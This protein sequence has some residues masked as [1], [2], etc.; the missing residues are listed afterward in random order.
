MMNPTRNLARLAG[1]LALAVLLAACGGG[2][3]HQSEGPRM[4]V[5]GV[6][7][8]DPGL[9]QKFMDEGKMPNFK[10]L[11]EMGSFQPLGTSIPPLSP[12]A[13]SNFMTGLDSGG[14]GIFDFVHRDPGTMIPFLATSKTTPPEYLFKVGGYQFPDPFNMGGTENMRRGQAFWEILEENGVESSIIRMPGNYPPTATASR[15]LSGMGT[16]DIK[17]SPGEFSWYTSVLFAFSGRDISG[18]EVFEVWEEEGVVEG[19]IEGPPSPFKTDGKET[20]VELKAY[21]DPKDD[22]VKLEIGDEEVVLEA[23]EFSDWVPVVFDQLPSTASTLLGTK[24]E[25]MV[26]FY[27]RRV[28]PEFELYASPI[29]FDPMSLASGISHPPE[30]SAELAEMS[31]RFYSQGMPEDTKALTQSVM[32]RD[33]FLA[34]AEIA[35]REL[36]DQYRVVLDEFNEDR[37]GRFLYYYFGNLDQVMHIMYKVIDPE[38][39]NYDPETDPAYAGVIEQLYREADEVIGHTLDNMSDDTMLVVMSD[40]GFAP[41]R[42]RM[43]LNTWLARNGFLTLKNPD[44]AKDPGLYFNV[45]WSKTRAYASGLYGV[46]VNLKGREKDGIVEERDRDAVLQELSE[47][48]L[49]QLDP[50]TGEPAVNK[51]YIRED[52]YNDRGYLDVGPDVV[53][54][55]AWSYGGNDESALGGVPQELFEDNTDEWSGDHGMDHETVPGVLFT[56]RPLKQPASDLREL[57]PALL[58]EFGITWKPS[59][60]ASPPTRVAQLKN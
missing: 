54:G 48:M 26:R 58:A 21:V 50:A 30:F 27:L 41:L 20:R 12:V 7:G 31:G 37:M 45:D 38:H 42:R 18:G 9:A 28:R 3:S 51:V 40:H 53:V 43:S 23:G 24:T 36:R 57:A 10:R 32:T 22:V 11:A 15:E 8:M 2:S 52:A 5:L 35:G 47:K 44:L 4:I 55:F 29:N 14:H 59:G 56:S 17:G 60:G 34:Q 49:A 46:Y 13:W 33:E 6:D 25:G 1:L 39:P 19:Y 16:P